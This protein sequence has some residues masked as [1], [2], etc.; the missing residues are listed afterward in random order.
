MSK[1]KQAALTLD[2]VIRTLD[3]VEVHGEKNLNAL[4]ACIQTLKQVTAQL[5]ETEEAVKE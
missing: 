4:L 3:S 2:Q 1:V 5:N